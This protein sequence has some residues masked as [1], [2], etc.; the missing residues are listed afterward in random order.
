MRRISCHW[1]GIVSEPPENCMP[2]FCGSLSACS[3]RTRLQSASSSSAMII[4]R[5][6]VTPCPMSG[7]RAMMRTRS[8]GVT[9]T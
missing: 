7:L 5:L 4:G 1:V 8:S 2:Y 3:I 9:S 6:V